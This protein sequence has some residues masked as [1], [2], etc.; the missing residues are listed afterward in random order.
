MGQI[1]IKLLLKERGVVE[2]F[3]TLWILVY[4]MQQLEFLTFR[5]SGW[6]ILLII[7]A[8]ELG[9]HLLLEEANDLTISDIAQTS[10]S[11][12]ILELI[13]E[14]LQKLEATGIW[15]FLIYINNTKRKGP[16]LII[17]LAMQKVLLIIEQ[18]RLLNKKRP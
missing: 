17:Q 16:M 5:T 3:H 12:H 13:W 4:L 18:F 10:L 1:I 11:V 2:Q 9:I 6:I 15:I 8:E 14:A 7:R